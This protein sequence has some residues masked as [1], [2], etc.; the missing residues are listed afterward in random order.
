MASNT[1]ATCPGRRRIKRSNWGH[2]HVPAAGMGDWLQRSRAQ[3][4]V[5]LTRQVAAHERGKLS[6]GMSQVCWF[7]LP[8]GCHELCIEVAV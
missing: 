1:S 4:G 5:L 8:R 2:E 7:L 3:T 6:Q